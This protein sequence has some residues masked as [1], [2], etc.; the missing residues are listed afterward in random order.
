MAIIN[1]N[2][3]SSEINLF[4]INFSQLPRAVDVGV[5]AQLLTKDQNG[6]TKTD[7]AG[8]FDFISDQ[9]NNIGL[10]RSSWSQSTIN[11]GFGTEYI[12]RNEIST[13]LI[14]QFNIP[15]NTLFSFQ[16][17]SSIN[18]TTF[19]TNPT[20]NNLSSSGNISI[21]LQN[22]S[23]QEIIDSLNLLAIVNTSFA[24]EMNQDYLRFRTSP[25][26][27][28]IH[29]QEDFLSSS[30]NQANFKSFNIN[31]A[32]IFRRYFEEPAL[33][34]FIAFTQSCNYASTNVDTCV[35]VN[36]PSYGIALILFL[37]LLTTRT[38]FSRI[39]KH[40]INLTR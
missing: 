12:A 35:K 33:I 6:L 29:Y 36:E 11:Q 20:A 13:N 28:I 1:Y 2:F 23:T 37:F 18:L 3:S 8:E 15:A 31:N 17:Q 14:G 39:M 4:I 24:E 38:H 27:T 19:T 22:S 16:L 10:A 9:I 25:N 5:D 34:D 30:G 7:V 32:V 40:I 26:F 21:A